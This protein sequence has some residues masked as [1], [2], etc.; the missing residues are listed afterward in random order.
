MDHA[1]DNPSVIN[2]EPPAERLALALFV[3]AGVAGFALFYEAPPAW[4]FLLPCAISPFRRW[5]WIPRIPIRRVHFVFWSLPAL[6]VLLAF[7]G[8]TFPSMIW[9]DVR[10]YARWLGYVLS[11]AASLSLVLPGLGSAATVT[12]PLSLGL[13]LTLSLI[14]VH[15][16]TAPLITWLPL[17]GGLA[18]T[19]IYLFIR[20]QSSPPRLPVLTLVRGSAASAV[21]VAIA[22]GLA[23]FL[24]WFQP[25]VENFVAGYLNRA[26]AGF[27]SLD[28]ECTLGEIEKLKL[29][30]RIVLRVWTDRPQYLRGRAYLDFDGRR[31]AA[32][33]TPGILNTLVRLS[34]AEPDP[35]ADPGLARWLKGV[36]GLT[37]PLPGRSVETATGPGAVR[38]R[39]VLAVPMPRLLLAPGNTVLVRSDATDLRVDPAETV[40]VPH[41]DAGA[42]YA[43]VS[44][45]DDDATVAVELDPATRAAAMTLPNDTDPRF[46]ELAVRLSSGDPSPEERVR[47]TVRHLESEC[48]YSLEPGAFTSDQPTAEFLFEKKKGY[49]AYFASAVAVLLRAQGVPCRFLSG[50]H[51]GGVNAV[52]DHYVVRDLDAHAWVEAWLPGRGWT[53]V[54]PTPAAEYEALHAGDDPGWLDAAGEWISSRWAMLWAWLRSGDWIGLAGR[55]IGWI[56]DLL[57]HPAAAALLLALAAAAWIRNRNRRIRTT[58]RPGAGLPL[59]VAAILARLDREWARRGHPRPAGRAPLE[60]FH[61]LPKGVLP[62]DRQGSVQRVIMEIYEMIYGARPSEDRKLNGLTELL[63]QAFR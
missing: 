29:S 47:R 15:P 10:V 1:K 63:D 14:P 54:D 22:V 57:L 12:W 46:A 49:C 60:H 52:G 19:A 26:T 18:S 25:R 3:A 61:A 33:K 30:R 41:D 23:L 16:Y 38:S 44:R 27:S 7:F 8:G 62:D 40:V 50:F 39:I 55:L 24:S 35:A 58:S 13:L 43:V 45:P 56:L 11:A 53:T 20:R 21:S 2:P 59:P 48:R 36:P 4:I 51:V 37:H 5:E 34:P 31:W 42:A 28:S 17:L 32:P 6:A 9:Q